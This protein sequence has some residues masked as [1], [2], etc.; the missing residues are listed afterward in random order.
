M[1]PRRVSDGPEPVG[2]KQ[3]EKQDGGPAKP[4]PRPGKIKPSPLRLFHLTKGVSYAD[5]TLD[6]SHYQGDAHDGSTID[7]MKPASWNLW[8]DGGFLVL[9]VAKRGAASWQDGG[10]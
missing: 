7:S 1:P 9:R 10:E 3:K 4:N 6:V 5:G 2:S 8:V